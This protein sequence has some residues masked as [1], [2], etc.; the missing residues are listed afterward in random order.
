MSEIPFVELQAFYRAQ[1]E[2]LDQVWNRV[3]GSSWFLLGKELES[4]ERQYSKY[5]GTKHC[6]G[7]GSG[8]DALVLLLKA[9]GIGKGDEVIVPAHTF[10]A[11]WL[12]VEK[13][14]AIP[15]GV[16]IDTKS[17]NINVSAI[18]DALTSRTR[19]I[20]FVNLYGLLADYK[21]IR[22]IGERH[23]LLILEDAAQSHGAKKDGKMSGS[24]AK[25]AAH[26]FYPGKNLGAFGDGGAITTNDGELAGRLRR[27]RNYGSN[28]K[29]HHDDLGYNSR[30][31]ELQAGILSVK[32]G[33]LPE[34]NIRR[35]Q[36]AK[37]YGTAFGKLLNSELN[38]HLTADYFDQYG[39]T[40]VWHL[41]VIRVLK[42]DKA[43]DLLRKSGIQTLVHYPIPCHLS[44]AFEYRKYVRGEFPIT[45]SVC[46]TVLSLPSS[47]FLDE[48]QSDRVI[49]GVI[50]LEAI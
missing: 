11:T 5:C 14:G 21:S 49:A 33:Q 3:T 22:R 44:K 28:R 20:I 19:C 23:G 29:Y 25:G 2:E 34:W 16:D 27:L 18:E 4:F 40:H 24:L 13:V 8:L 35:R 48:E 41:F 50:K 36:V 12:A 7:V 9:N 45:E 31:D 6:I 46:D 1:K 42:R 37:K 43:Q 47:P 10:I 30:L 32:L 38:S 17:F 26:S 39:D 15:V